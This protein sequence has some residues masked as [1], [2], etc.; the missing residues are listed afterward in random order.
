M[1]RSPCC[2]APARLASQR[3]SFERPW[4]ALM[5]AG[6]L[7]LAPIDIVA[8]PV[9]HIDCDIGRRLRIKRHTCLPWRLI[10]TNQFEYCM[11]SVNAAPRFCLFA[12]F[13]CRLPVFRDAVIDPEQIGGHDD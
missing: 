9:R 5:D 7:H 11:P 3:L 1:T 10:V 6:R 4:V 2:R 13:P 8:L 12:A